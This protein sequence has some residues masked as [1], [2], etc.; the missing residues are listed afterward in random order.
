MLVNKQDLANLAFSIILSIDLSWS[1]IFVLAYPS[2]LIFLTALSNLTPDNS[3]GKLKSLFASVRHKE[4]TG[5][6]LIDLVPL[7]MFYV[8]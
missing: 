2:I 3:G 6:K 7:I 1:S 4:E 5:A 8:L